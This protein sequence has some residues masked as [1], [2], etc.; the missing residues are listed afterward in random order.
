MRAEELLPEV[1]APLQPSREQKRR[2]Y[3]LMNDLVLLKPGDIRLA[4]FF[5]DQDVRSICCVCAD[6]LLLLGLG[7][8]VVLRSACLQCCGV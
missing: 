4:K 7:V 5:C 1:F 8:L 2:F 6:T 3:S